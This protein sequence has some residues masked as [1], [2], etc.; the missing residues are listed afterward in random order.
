[1]LHRI[2]SCMVT[3]LSGA[4][5]LCERGKGYNSTQPYYRSSCHL[6]IVRQLKSVCTFWQGHLDL[7]KQDI[8][9]LADKSDDIVTQI[10]IWK[11]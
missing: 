10:I 7:I 11:F 3:D 2:Y 8:M 6:D 9:K 5:T 1:M 4:E